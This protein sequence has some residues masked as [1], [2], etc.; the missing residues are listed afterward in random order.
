MKKAVLF[1]MDGV[2]IDS[3]VVM[4]HAAME[5]FQP[6]GI[7]ATPED[8]APYVGAGENAYLG[9]VA[10]KYGVAYTPEVRD[11]V[12]DVYGEKINRSYTCLLYTSD[13]AD[14]L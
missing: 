5:G 1:D 7:D 13:A 2:L 8:F 3:E 9:N 12:Y 10:R 11:H 4:L 6:F 14:E